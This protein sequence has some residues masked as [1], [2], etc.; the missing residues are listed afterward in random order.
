MA[1]ALGFPYTFETIASNSH[2]DPAYKLANAI[3]SK[4]PFREAKAVRLPRPEFLQELPLLPNGQ[5]AEIHD[6]YMQ[7]LAFEDFMLAN[8]HALPLHV[9]GSSYDSDDGRAFAKEV[10]K[11]MLEH[12]ATPLIFCGDFNH[13]DIEKLYPNLFSELN[14]I[15]ALPN[16]ASVLNSELR[17]DYMLIS[18][19]A[20]QIA[21]AFIEPMMTDHFSCGLEL[22]Y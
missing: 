3:I 6:K 2:I 21:H 20:F 9:L 1:R 15:E 8:I 12:L 13:N 17:I 14:L 11:V 16:E 22:Y 10:E 7:V 19:D 4:K 5:H 18:K